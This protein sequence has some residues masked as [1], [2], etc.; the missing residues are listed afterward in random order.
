MQMVQH[1]HHV[2]PASGSYSGRPHS[3]AGSEWTSASTPRRGSD[4]SSPITHLTQTAGR[5]SPTFGSPLQGVSNENSANSVSQVQNESSP[6]SFNSR[7]YVSKE[8]L[9]DQEK[10]AL[11]V[12]ARTPEGKIWKAERAREQHQNYMQQRSEWASNTVIS[13]LSGGKFS[14]AKPKSDLDWIVFYAKQLP[15]PGAHNPRLPPREGRKEQAKTGTKFGTA[16]RFGPDTIDHSIPGAG[17]YNPPTRTFSTLGGKFNGSD[18]VST[19][20][21]SRSYLSLPSPPSPIQLS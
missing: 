15:G 13:E 11:I 19:L 14:A 17:A 3:Q 16:S 4:R 7:D 12:F 18:N 10:Q 1:V 5:V 21:R 9:D 8:D 2:R 6:N 20:S